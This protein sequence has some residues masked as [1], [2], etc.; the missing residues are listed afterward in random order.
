MVISRIPLFYYFRTVLEV[1]TGFLI[2]DLSSFVLSRAAVLFLVTM[3]PLLGT[4][5]VRVRETYANEVTWL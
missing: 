1:F 3:S 2:L 5:D 4:P